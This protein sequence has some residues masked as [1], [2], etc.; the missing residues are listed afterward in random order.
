MKEFGKKHFKKIFATIMLVSIVVLA[1]FTMPQNAAEI[2]RCKINIVKSG[3]D[4]EK[5]NDD[6]KVLQQIVS[7]T[8]KELTVQVDFENYQ[9]QTTQIAMVIDNS[10]S[11]WSEDKLINSKSK[12]VELVENIFTNIPNVE[13][14][15][16]AYDGTKIAMGTDKDT[17][18]S[19]INAITSYQG[20]TT[21]TGITYAKNTFTK[22]DANKYIILF[23]DGEEKVK[24]VTTD[25]KNSNINLLTAFYGDDRSVYSQ[26]QIAGT[27]FTVSSVTDEKLATA[28]SRN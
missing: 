23:T 12:I 24:D 6:V 7:S 27:V 11:M 16:S 13:L 8:D 20:I 21:K 15:L 5:K 22:D 14:S 28:I 1:I 18:I 25:L 4:Q 2:N 9:Y 10:Y 26:Y 17:V 3:S 19:Q